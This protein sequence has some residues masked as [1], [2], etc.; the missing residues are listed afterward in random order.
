MAQKS[1][2]DMLVFTAPSGWSE[3]TKANMVMFSNY[4]ANQTD[5]VSLMVFNKFETDHKT[6][7]VFT[8]TWRKIFGLQDTATA[9]RPRKLYTNDSELF[10]MGGAEIDGLE[11]F[12]YYQLSVYMKPPFAQVILIKYANAKTWKMQQH[13]YME[14]LLAV[15][16]Q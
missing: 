2:F 1:R 9:P 14:Q 5:P 3:Q 11:G 16:I 10:Y 6:P 4:N 8:E 13:E 12:G 15:K 7:L